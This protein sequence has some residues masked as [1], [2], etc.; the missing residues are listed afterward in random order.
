MAIRGSYHNGFAPRDAEP[1]YPQLWTSCINALSPGLGPSGA[2]LRDWSGF[3][4]DGVLTNMDTAAA[5]TVSGGRYGLAFDGTDDHVISPVS[6]SSFSTTVSASMWV[7]WRTSAAATKGVFSIASSLSSGSPWMLFQRD[8][9]NVRWY[10]AGGYRFTAAIAVDTWNHFCAT[11]NGAE[12]IFYTNGQVAGTYTGAFGVFAGAR[13]YIG[14]GFNGYADCIVDDFMLHTNPL[15]AAQV[16]ALAS[17]RGIAYEMRSR[18]RHSNQ[19]GGAAAIRRHLML[20][21]V[22]R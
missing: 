17:R 14:N 7:M 18:R 11:Y 21:G 5:W 8:S 2:V 4:N 20:L 3:K 13:T 6:K 15:S 12:W 19:D 1:L 22:G 9:G 10:V 16:A